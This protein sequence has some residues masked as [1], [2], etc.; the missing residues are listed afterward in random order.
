MNEL[1]RNVLRWLAWIAY[2][3]LAGAGFVVL[4]LGIVTWLPALAAMAD[5]LRGWRRDGEERCFQGVFAAFPR[6]ARALLPHSVLSTGAAALIVVD[7]GFLAGRPEPVAFLLLCGLLGAAI[8][9]VL[10]HLGLAVAA[11]CDSDAGT[12]AWRRRALVLAFGSP[13]RTLTWL[14]TVIAAPVLSLVV[15]FGPLL[16]GPSLPVLLGLHEEGR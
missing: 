5:S 10:Y 1:T 4:S 3:A 11:A 7:I 12:A 9:F 15:P 16:L 14:A 8:A 6:Y 2:P 13:R